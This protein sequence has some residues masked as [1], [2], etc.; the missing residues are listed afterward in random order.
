[1]CTTPA[2]V[3]GPFIVGHTVSVDVVTMDFNARVGFSRAEGGAVDIGIVLQ[4][5]VV[6]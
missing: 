6:P 3:G 1:M 5:C 4:A 2:H